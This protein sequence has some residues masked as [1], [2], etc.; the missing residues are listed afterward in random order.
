M[1]L[2]NIIRKRWNNVLGYD[3][4]IITGLEQQKA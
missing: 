3:A 2:I 1:R 4:R